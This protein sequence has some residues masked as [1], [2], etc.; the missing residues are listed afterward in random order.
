[1]QSRSYSVVDSSDKKT[2][3][4]DKHAMIFLSVAMKKWFF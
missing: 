4:G 2:D 3:I 1:M